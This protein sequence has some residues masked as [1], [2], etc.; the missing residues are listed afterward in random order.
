MLLRLIYLVYVFG[1]LFVP[2][3]LL[4]ED[5]GSKQGHGSIS[6]RL[7]FYYNGDDQDGNPFLDEELTVIEP[8]I[9]FDYNVSE[10]TS[11][12]GK[13]SY[14]YVSS[15]SIDRLSNY[16]EQSGAS[17]DY[18]FGLD[19]GANHQL[20]DSKTIGGF[21]SGSVEYDYRS[22]GLG[23]HYSWD[24]NQRN[25]RFKISSNAFYDQLDIIRFNGVEDGT[26]SRI[27][28]TSS[29]TWYQIINSKTHSESGI[30]LTYQSGFLETPYNAV[31]IEDSSLPPNPALD[32]NAR[33]IEITEEL[34]DTRLRLALYGKVKRYITDGHALALGS[35][36]YADSW[37][38]LGV[39][40]Q[41]SV[42][43][44]LVPE[45]FRTQLRYR[46]YSQ[47][48]AD[49][50][51]KSFTT[52]TSQRTQDSD[53]G[54]FVSHGAGAT[55]YWHLSPTLVWDI[56]GDYI[57]RDDGLDQIQISTGFQKKF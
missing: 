14:D 50:Y 43:S 6:S 56:G 34:D 51:S 16:P 4:A 38:I 11:M 54:S 39:S 9:F 13:F 2:T 44:W 12:W 37:G 25:T 30:S 20:S 41:P 22:F 46:V 48:E 36:L 26:D 32:N 15:A 3:S 45:V 10:E 1:I 55:F 18:Y 47:S 23:G 31:V 33:G 7:G 27:S 57:L 49:D 19:L 53:L 35:R 21:L 5:S 8:S 24:T 28:I 29:A 40:L 52:E 42:D 17:G